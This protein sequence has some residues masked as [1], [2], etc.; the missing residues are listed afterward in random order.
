MAVVNET[1]TV[2]TRDLAF[3]LDLA[4]PAISAAGPNRESVNLIVAVAEATD[5]EALKVHARLGYG[6]LDGGEG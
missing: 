6:F 1:V 3:L 4:R 2:N 5:D